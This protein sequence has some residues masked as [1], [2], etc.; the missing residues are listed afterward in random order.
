MSKRVL[1]NKDYLET[2]KI[3]RKKT[4]R[5][6]LYGKINL[7]QVK[8]IFEIFTNIFGLN[9]DTNECSKFTRTS[10]YRDFIRAKTQKKVVGIL[11]KNDKL[12]VQFLKDFLAPAITRSNVHY[13][14]EEISAD[15]G[16]PLSAADKG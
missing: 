7:E 14:Q 8:T 9:R 1:A 3:T 10:L 6:R 15:S 16:R 13:E 2:I 5:S 4:D 12:F 11:R